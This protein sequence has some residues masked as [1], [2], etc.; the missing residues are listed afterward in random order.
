MDRPLENPES[1]QTANPPQP[2]FIDSTEPA[3][4]VVRLSAFRHIS[5][6]RQSLAEIRMQNLRLPALVIAFALAGGAT[7]G[8]TAAVTQHMKQNSEPATLEGQVQNVVSSEE[9]KNLANPSMPVSSETHS[10]TE[11]HTLV[12]PRKRLR[13]RAKPRIPLGLTY[14]DFDFDLIP[15]KKR[16]PKK[17][18]YN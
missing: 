5:W 18:G 17:D 13:R 9:A 2:R 11:A 1:L 3:H 8:L 15:L 12:R 6:L 16:H 7:G 10:T 14:N 4:Q